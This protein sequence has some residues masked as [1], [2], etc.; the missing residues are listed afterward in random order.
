[1]T[2]AQPCA[3]FSV[4]LFTDASGLHWGA[5]VTQVQDADRW[6]G[7]DIADLHQPLTFPSGSFRGSQLRWP[8]MDKEA[9]AIVELLIKGGLTF[10][11]RYRQH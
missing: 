9:L 5:M 2:L 1:M 4:M 6:I 11:G 3:G 8:T 10:L 7:G